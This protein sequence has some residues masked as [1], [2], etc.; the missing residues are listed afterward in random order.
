MPCC[1]NAEMV[2]DNVSK[3]II[4]IC[5][6]NLSLSAQHHVWIAKLHLL[7]IPVLKR[8]SYHC[9]TQRNKLVELRLA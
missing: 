2:E 7:M 5:S 3:W 9:V 6:F 4:R 8:V 1:S